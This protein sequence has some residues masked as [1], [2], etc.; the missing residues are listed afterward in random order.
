MVRAAP[1]FTLG[2]EE[3]Y[4]LVDVET[5]DLATEPPDEIYDVC[6]RRCPGQVSPEYMRCQIEIGTRVCSNLTEARADL[7]SLR[8][9]IVEVAEK[10]GLA[11]IAA[12]SR[13]A[14]NPLRAARS[15]TKAAVGTKPV[16]ISAP[17]TGQ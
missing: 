3:E 10:Y 14:S 8:S 2:I 6:E 11:P 5:G 16:V 9:M 15:R 1:A 7:A 4:L 17:C 12:S 13:A